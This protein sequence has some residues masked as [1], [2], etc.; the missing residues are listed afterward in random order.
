[1]PDASNANPLVSIVIRTKDRRETLD[2]AL[3]SC[4][5]QRY[6]PLEIVVVNDGGGDMSDL[7]GPIAGLRDIKVQ[8][9]VHSV[10]RGRCHAGNAGLDAASGRLLIFL[11]DDDWLEP[12]HI[13]ALADV[14]SR[15]P[16]V[17]AAY[18][19][20]R[21]RE[22]P[23]AEDIALLNDP[24]DPVAQR[25]EN[26]IPIHAV[27]F[28]RELLGL[29]CR[30]DPAL[31]VFEDWDFWLQCAEF[32]D[33]VHLDQVSAGYRA[34][35]GSNAGW[36]QSAERVAQ[37]RQR[38]LAKWKARW[39][40]EQLD[41][42]LRLPQERLGKAMEAHRQLHEEHEAL[43]AAHDRLNADHARLHQEFRS[44]DDAY[45]IVSGALEALQAKH[46]DLIQAHQ[47]LEHLHD[48]LLEKHRDLD[49]EYHDLR[50]AQG[51][52]HEAFKRTDYLYREAAEA[53]RATLASTSWRVTLPI[54]VVSQGMQRVKA[55]GRAAL[56]PLPALLASASDAARLSGGWRRLLVKLVSRVRRDGLGGSIRRVGFHMQRRSPRAAPA[57]LTL[58]SPPYCPSEMQMAALPTLRCGIMAHVFFVDLFPELCRYL[59]KMPVAYHLMVSVSSQADRER[60]LG[61]RALLGDKAQLTV[62]VL[63]NRGRDI[64]PL[65]VG[66]REEIAAL[67]VVGHIHTKRSSYTGSPQFG[68]D[69]RRYL[70]ESMLGDETRFRA[71]LA[72]FAVDA[73]VGLIYPETF[74][75]LPYWAHTWLSNRAHA[76]ALLG[77]LGF[78]DVDFGQYIDYPA[79]SMFW[80]RTQALRPLL[81][82]GLGLS[83]F[84]PEE[85]Q[86][87]NTL[88]HAIERCLT[89]SAQ[90]AGLTRRLLFCEQGRHCLRSFSPF[91]LSHYAPH[92]LAERI[93][94]GCAD[95]PLVSFD[96]FDTLILRPFARPE[97]VFWMLEE[98]VARDYGIPDFTARRRQAEAMARAVLE[99]G[100]DVAVEAIYRALA[101]ML[102]LDEARAQALLQLEVTTEQGLFVVN[103]VAA[104]ALKALDRAGRRLILVSDMYLG[105]AHL[106]P[107]LARL[108][109][110]VFDRLYVSA[111]TGRRKD[112]G[113]IWEHVL[114][115]ED[116]AQSQL[117]HVGDNE[118]SDVQVL[119]DRG[120]PHPVHVMRPAALL[121][122][123]PGGQA[124]IRCFRERP[125]WRNELILGLVA[126]RVN[127]HLTTTPE[128]THRP[129]AD[130]DVFGYGIIGPIVFVFMAWLI[131]RLQEDG[132]TSARFLS[133][134]GWLLERLYG[135]MRSH[136]AVSAVAPDLPAGVYCYCSR[137]VVGL[138]AIRD[139][140]DLALLLAAHYDGSFRQ[141]LTARFGLLDVEDIAAKLGEEVLDE[142]LRL[143]EDHHRIQVLLR[144]CLPELLKAS[145]VLRAAV[146]D[147]WAG[148]GCAED[149]RPAIIDIGYSG[150]IQLALMQVLEQPL[151]GYYAVTNTSAGRVLD[152]GGGCAS[153]FGHL[154]PLERMDR[155][156]IHRYALV[157]E[158]VLTS[159][160]GQL[161][162]FERRDGRVMPVFKPGGASQRSF[163]TLERIH[164]GALRFCVDVL[165]AVGSAALRGDWD[166]RAVS[167]LL[168]LIV[169]RHLDIGALSQALSVEDQYCGNQELSV[170]DFYDRQR[171]A[172]GRL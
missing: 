3:A 44:R 42:A 71:V 41:A 8:H 57:M 96:L 17:M 10:S 43:L 47:G 90:A 14:L 63:P 127:R 18:A 64:A 150:T 131:R 70:L 32:T 156:A 81:D 143:P 118:H 29:G 83:D 78:T 141:L 169:D 21:Y 171:M 89:F 161:G 135:A 74:P 116:V 149:Q 160:E 40:A 139:E 158:A 92:A 33:F 85:G 91:V 165:D 12:E 97:A 130:P 103:P 53:Y 65:I 154:L 107:V 22:S 98:E 106:R 95:A 99:P 38:L 68:E 66:F 77:R 87:D 26:H 112:R 152:G 2:Y 108:G 62:K 126:N 170:L 115:R 59:A 104:D 100:Q 20:V 79:G 124:F 125:S 69:W 147:Y 119:V 52:L 39:S 114:Q 48:D 113:D 120:F 72:Q 67:D 46:T 88:H 55:R 61:Q 148:L 129:F 7:V 11:D 134:E 142:N 140:A 1:M 122:I 28:R 109:L 172:S 50:F 82:L 137:S 138:A 56:G 51:E 166:L 159:P 37:A 27:L 75:G 101:Q 121:G 163:P 167:G 23:D 34:G 15:R 36:G 105:E 4:V 145:A 30:L 19:G 162:G 128:P 5:A 6:R 86:T 54:R 136:P 146:R 13:G 58:D 94:L 24:Y 157:L 164:E 117:Q 31:D 93:R 49:Q 133:R 151:S 110:D 16:D 168:P 25:L 123:L 80:A 35:G 153:C 144:D 84:P 45:R 111:D 155:E 76:E 60:V 73:S 132:A 102:K 9:L